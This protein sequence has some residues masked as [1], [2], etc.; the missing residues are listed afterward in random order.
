[1]TKTGY[2]DWLRKLNKAELSEGRDAAKYALHPA[3]THESTNAFW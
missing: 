1:M 3:A 2:G